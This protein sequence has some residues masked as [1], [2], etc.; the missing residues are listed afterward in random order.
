MYT[1]NSQKRASRAALSYFESSKFELKFTLVERPRPQPR[2]SRRARRI[3]SSAPP[4]VEALPVAVAATSTRRGAIRAEGAPGPTRGPHRIRV[5]RSSQ[6]TP[7]HSRPARDGPRGR[8]GARPRRAPVA[9]RC[10]DTARIGPPAETPRGSLRCKPRSEAPPG[11]SGPESWTRSTAALWPSPRMGALPAPSLNARYPALLPTAS[12]EAWPCG[13]PERSA[14][15]PQL[16]RPGSRDPPPLTQMLPRASP[17]ASPSY[18]E[19][20]PSRILSDPK[21]CVSPGDPRRRLTW[22]RPIPTGARGGLPAP[23]VGGVSRA[24]RRQART[25]AQAGR[26]SGGTGQPFSVRRRRLRAVPGRAGSN[27]G[28]AR[29]GLL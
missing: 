19:A 29:P 11:P 23:G 4:R 20:T 21:R 15:W 3:D 1:R 10:R 14:R 17:K 6:S 28:R 8:R 2:E 13:G 27:P 12:A 25:A 16:T 5:P 22:P 24:A 9:A 18:P 7:V 26:G